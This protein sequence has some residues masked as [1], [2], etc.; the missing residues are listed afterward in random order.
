M[1]RTIA[2][3][4]RP[5]EDAGARGEAG[6]QGDAGDHGHDASDHERWCSG[7]KA[8]RQYTRER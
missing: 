6:A 8:N 4:P 5:C 3:Q 2:L 1:L 7:D